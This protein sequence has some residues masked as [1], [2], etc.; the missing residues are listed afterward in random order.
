MAENRELADLKREI[1]ETRNQAI[2]TD[3]QVKNLGLDVK[4]FEKRF[5]LLERRTR[6]ASLGANVIVAVVIIAA[7][8]L[9]HSVRTS[10][11][12]EELEA[13]R[14]TAEKAKSHA[15]EE[16]GR[17]AERVAGVEGSAKK[18]DQVETAI[19]AFLTHLEAG[20]DK[21]AE[22]LLSDIDIEA[23]GPAMKKLAA[24]KVREFRRVSAETAY[25]SGRTHVGAGRAQ[26]GIAELRRCLELE[27]DGRYA[28]QAAY[29]LAT[30]LWNLRKFDEATVVL[31]DMQKRKIDRSV[32]N[33]VQF[34][35]GASLAR[36]GKKDEGLAILKQIVASGNKFAGTSKTYVA[37]LEAGSDLPAFPGGK[38]RSTAARPAA[39]PAP[40]T[41][42]PG[43]PLAPR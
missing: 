26:A 3:N 33:E 17:M 16:T 32:A 36:A 13:S 2:K 7:A 25:K 41:P 8:Y 37:A 30:N 11:L 1:V 22:K 28:T 31:R 23:A 15:A 6:M 42:A 9:I 5:D 12:H 18:R 20:R 43:A 14:A 4:G 40:P 34:L 38:P 39:T 24:T 27:P 19:V 29:L 21:S 10:S 35:L